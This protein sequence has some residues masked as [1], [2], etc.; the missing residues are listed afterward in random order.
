MAEFNIM[1]THSEADKLIERMNND[2]ENNALLLSLPDAM[3]RSGP[4]WQEITDERLSRDEQDFLYQHAQEERKKNQLTASQIFSRANPELS[5]AVRLGIKQS[6]MRR[7]YEQLFGN[8]TDEFVSSGSVASMFSPAGYLTEL[9][10]EAHDLHAVDSPFSL[11]RRRPDLAQLV[12]S[13]RNMDEEI[14]TLSLSNELLLDLIKGGSDQT[15]ED[16]LAMLA[17]YRQTGG[18]PFH[19][20]YETIRQAIISQDKEFAV[21][22]DN[23]DVLGQVDTA[24]LN[25]IRTNISP[26]L[27]E[28]LLE[29]IT[30]D[31]AEAMVRKNF[32]DIDV[33]PFR[34]IPFL[35]RYYGMTNE[36]MTELLGTVV[37]DGNYIHGQQYYRNDQLISVQQEGS[38]L[39]ARILH[40]TYGGNGNQ[41]HF[42]ELLPLETNNYLFSFTT[43]TGFSGPA[44][45]VRIG[46]T[47]PG[48]A[49]IIRDQNLIPGN[50][51]PVT[52]P[53]TFSDDALERGITI[54]ITR[55]AV[56]GGSFQYVTVNFIQTRMSFHVLLLKLNKLIRLYQATGVSAQN[57]RA[58]LDMTGS[59]LA[60][61]QNTLRQ[62]FWMNQFMQ[63]YGTGRREA[64]TLAGAPVSQT[65]YGYQ[66]SDFDELFNTPPMSSQDFRPD[67]TSLSLRPGSVSDTFRTGIMKRAFRVNDAGLYTLWC[68]ARGTTTPPPFICNLQNISALY[69]LSLLAKVHNL[70]VSELAMLVSVSPYAGMPLGEL[71]SEAL[72]QLIIMLHHT[73]Q[74]L[75]RQGV[76]ATELFMM[77]TETVTL[78]MTPEA[79]SLIVTLQN[80]LANLSVTADEDEQIRSTAPFIAA[81]A[82]MD[83]NET[84]AAVLSWINQQR[85]AGL[86]VTQFLSLVAS[87][88][89]GDNNAS[90]IR[91]CHRLAQLT[92]IVRSLGLS[93]DE[94]EFVVEHPGAFTPG[95]QVLPNT[96]LTVR[97]LSRFH[98]FLQRTGSAASELLAALSVGSLTPSQLATALRLDEQ[99]V[100]QGLAQLNT[101]ATTFTG[102]TDID[103]T[104]QWVNVAVTLGITP[105]GVAT[106]M[107]LKYQQGNMQP[108]SHW[109]HASNIIQAGLDEHQTQR[110]QD[111]LDEALS[112]ALS[113][114]VIKNLTPGQVT[115]RDK[116]YSWLLLDNQVSASI[117]T[118]RIAEAISSLQLYVNRGLNGLEE[119]ISDVVRARRFLTEW[120]IYNKRYSTWAGV[121]RLVYYPE[122]YIDPTTRIGQTGMMDDMLH[123]LSQSQL[124]SDSV[125]D[126]FSAYMTRF[127]EIADL[128]VISAYH[129]STTDTAGIS[130]FIGH[131]ATTGKYYWRTLDHD[132]E[133]EGLFPANAWSE[134]IEIVTAIQPF[135]RQVR[136]VFF[137]SRLYVVWLEQRQVSSN[138]G[139]NRMTVHE[140]RYSFRRHDG[141]WSV[142]TTI[143]LADYFQEAD[144]SNMSP[145]HLFC[146]RILD[147][148]SMLVMLYPPG[149]NSQ[150]NRNTPVLGLFIDIHHN[151]TLN[152]AAE[153]YREHLWQ[154]MDTQSGIKIPQQYIEQFFVPSS[155]PLN[156]GWGFDEISIMNGG[157]VQNI[158]IIGYT[159]ATVTLQADVS[160]RVAFQGAS[161]TRR[162]I[163][164]DL[165]KRF[166]APGDTFHIYRS[167]AY[168]PQVSL[169]TRLNTPVY[170]L[171]GPGRPAGELLIHRTVGATTLRARVP[172][173]GIMLSTNSR[174][175]EVSLPQQFIPDS[176][177]VY[178]YIY[179]EDFLQAATDVDDGYTLN[180]GIRPQDVMVNV[181]AGGMST[182]FN[183]RDH[184][185]AAELPEPDFDGM[186][187]VFRGLTLNVPR[188]AFTGGRA[189]VGFQLSAVSM[190]GHSLGRQ[191]G[192]VVVSQESGGAAMD[193]LQGTRAE[194]YLQKGAFR[195]RLNTLFARSL[196]DRARQ[197]LSAVLSME[198]QRL[199]EPMLGRGGYVEIRFMRYSRPLHGDGWFRLFFLG[200]RNSGTQYRSRDLVAT[201]QVSS[202]E[203]TT[204]R[205]FVPFNDDKTH[206]PLTVFIGVQYSDIDLTT[207]FVNMQGFTYDLAQD[208]FVPAQQ[209]PSRTRGMRSTLLDSRSEPMDFRGANALYFWEM[210]YYVPMMAFKRLLDEN[211]FT[212][213]TRWI[214]FIWSPEGYMENGQPAPYQWNVRPLE[215]DTSWNASPLDSVDP[216]AVAQADPMHYKVATFMAWLDLLIARGDMAYRRLE[217]DT[218]S[219][220]KMWYVQALG[221]L[222]QRPFLVD[223]TRWSNP[224]LSDAA[225][226]TR[227]INTQEALLLTRSAGPVPEGRTANTL[228]DLFL[229][230]FNDKLTGYWQTLE[231]RLFNL[232]NNLTIDGQPL[233]L[234][235]FSTPASPAALLSAAVNGFR[236][237]SSLPVA[238]MTIWRFPI[239]L[240]NAREMAGQLET[241]GNTLLSLTERQDDSAVSVMVHSH[242][243]Q[244]MHMGISQ[245]EKAIE[246]LDAER[247]ALEENVRGAQQRFKHF[248]QLSE[249]WVSAGE[250]QSLDLALTSNLLGTSA[251]MPY[252]VAAALDTLPNVYGLAFGGS[253]LGAMA[254]CVGG[255]LEITA[256]YLQGASDYI[257]RSE[258]YR[259]RLQEWIIE[260]DTC[261]SEIREGEAYLKM[262]AL[263]RE[264]AEMQKSYLEKEYALSIEEEAFIANQ[265]TGEALYS[266]LRGRLA[267]IYYQCYDLTVS[268]CLMAQEAYRWATGDDSANF[269]RPGAWQGTYGGLIAAET[270]KLNL[271]QM[272]QAWLSQNERER[273]VT[274]IVSLADVFR[275]L[276]GNS[277]FELKD[278]VNTLLGAGQGSAGTANTGLRI[279]DDQLQGMLRLSDLN[280]MQDY[281]LSLG[282]RRRIKQISVSL[283]DLAGP[284]Q[285]IR[286]VL[287]YGGSVILP[288]GCNSQVVSH[289][290]NDTGQLLLRFHDPR[291]LPFEGIP[292]NDTGILTLSFP[293][294]TGR[295]RNLLSNLQDIILHIHYTAIR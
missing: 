162:Q 222:G 76:G 137:N 219:E 127:E 179:I 31:N 99:I 208:V 100:S 214:K 156:F 256:E 68:L 85:P 75:G 205:L 12:L 135:N 235:V 216:D 21:F 79:E 220:A 80:G 201:G 199:E 234:P 227:Q 236:G 198:T 178:Q 1:N 267:A 224:Q 48:S 114:F 116:L 96:L 288:Q 245:Q 278:T 87:Y 255:A 140:L 119:G 111:T 4:E 112:R 73:T 197:G 141:T 17:T 58:V 211:R 107:G 120:D 261:E 290:V 170:R 253:H 62:L 265:F 90:L 54:G 32:G 20:P 217:R 50:G 34:H 225:D 91:F 188:S 16:V 194:Q 82:Q 98:A 167:I 158:H 94:V 286:A 277:R 193:I 259:R 244:L 269:I 123:A 237:G 49:D 59:G 195:T 184:I 67:G 86:T 117:R 151:V 241:F 192:T 89:P 295:Q 207:T 11:Q 84:A 45:R 249:E 126:A 146:S 149:A 93:A 15:Q 163:Q 38:A 26:E 206:D 228:L 41:L 70:N 69:R 270:L 125:E 42:A 46:T 44:H 279:N 145:P 37:Q 276:T 136:P 242:A 113:A 74:W 63:L 280:I 72:S 7:N 109:A 121:S 258:E 124:T 187:Y 169:S 118:T 287:S 174:D 215:E 263:Q 25:A 246:E 52:V 168:N 164:T 6:A 18:T 213:A 148:G 285:D 212:E 23:P 175:L 71:N 185:S 88:T 131:Q 56:S 284:Y 166:G 3:V 30:D 243:L 10:R 28:I 273:Q 29:E 39:E 97:N 103:V 77:T 53:A 115:D 24:T 139:Q 102:W 36:E 57:L 160:V 108:Y 40:R 272:E 172:S 203:E 231:R 13:Q 150:A 292:V 252:T 218:L 27:Y 51:I 189:N 129:D 226:R 22:V 275:S 81:A 128:G 5:N 233:V 257:A 8:R 144:I 223:S 60:V 161:N 157:A 64:I 130:Y 104:L 281:P 271:V 183:A 138:D 155:I 181:T 204:I 182:T 143:P 110:L 210:F 282:S 248:S 9:Y 190:S 154:Q 291:W 251:I 147:S 268:R 230:Q 196:V 14:S 177:F 254:Q 283:P 191:T 274:R 294:A 293:D 173:R 240:R 186:V 65:I 260:R 262:L 95:V 134:W 171:A 232:R 247:R 229:P 55:Y 152:T 159:D 238:Q 105:S 43:R 122:N 92:L 66:P 176:Q 142:V 202:E 200:A 133:T 78:R 180:T 209:N 19:L 47:G 289:G 153:A 221:I 61:D 33:T 239:M 2:V 250:R 35:A 132:K 106:L 101:Q 266:W 165:M 264:A 83:S